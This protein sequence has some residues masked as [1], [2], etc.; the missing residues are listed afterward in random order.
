MMIVMPAFAKG[1]DADKDVVTTLVSTSIGLRTPDVTDRVH[2]PGDVMDDHDP[3][4]PTPDESEKSASP[5]SL[6]DQNI[7]QPAEDRGDHKADGN[8]EWK[9]SADGPNPS[10]ADQVGNVAIQRLTGRIENPT[11]VSVPK[12][13]PDASKPG[14]VIVQMR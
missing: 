10:V 4:Q 3:N 1:E 8:P 7:G 6:A 5:E 13:R 14:S 9:Q 11:D 12:P 2:A